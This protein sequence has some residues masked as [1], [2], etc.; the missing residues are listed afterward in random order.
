[1]GAR[2]SVRHRDL[3]C[4]PSDTRPHFGQVIGA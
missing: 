4:N 2:V 3:T 1:M